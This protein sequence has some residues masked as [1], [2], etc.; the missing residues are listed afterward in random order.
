VKW[1]DGIGEYAFDRGP[2]YRIYLAKDGE[3]VLFGGGPQRGQQRDIDRAK[4]LSAA[5]KA[6]KKSLASRSGAGGK[7]R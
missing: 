5:Y 1:L 4:A 7:H 3:S 2:G 6:R